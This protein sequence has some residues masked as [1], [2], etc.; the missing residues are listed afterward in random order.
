MFSPFVIAVKV[1]RCLALF[2][3]AAAAASGSHNWFVI[4]YIEYLSSVKGIMHHHE[5][6]FKAATNYQQ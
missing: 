5:S 2:D 1:E 3:Q 4:E 6:S